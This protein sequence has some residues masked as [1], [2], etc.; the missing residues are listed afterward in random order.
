MK[1][2]T[3]SVCLNSMFKNTSGS[4]ERE[5]EGVEERQSDQLQ[6]TFLSS[7]DSLHLPK[8]LQLFP[9]THH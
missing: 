7:A 9:Q 4:E 6:L 8:L 2:S 3:C 5:R 1:G